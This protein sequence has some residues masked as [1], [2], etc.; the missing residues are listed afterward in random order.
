MK[1]RGKRVR[2]WRR[3]HK[4]KKG[5]K[6]HLKRKRRDE[7][8]FFDFELKKFILPLILVVLFGILLVNFFDLGSNLDSYTCQVPA[9]IKEF[10]A[11]YH[12][13]D[14]VAFNQSYAQI[15][16]MGKEF[17]NDMNDFQKIIPLT[18]FFKAIDPF[19]P[20]P[21]EYSAQSNFCRF[22]VNQESYVCSKEGSSYLFPSVYSI[23]E[24]EV[25][26]YNPIS[27]WLI[28]LNLIDLIVVGYLFS[29][30]VIYGYREVASWKKVI[31]KIE[32]K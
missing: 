12:N 30:I 20:V 6:A 15:E 7:K 22:Y 5:K 3:F 2:H 9:L 25:K 13:N 28:L 16:I 26:Q 1:K 11:N 31:I 32:K 21:C 4:S 14:S 8:K 27:V 24:S 18:S 23:N 29:C 19:V 17:E 10:Y